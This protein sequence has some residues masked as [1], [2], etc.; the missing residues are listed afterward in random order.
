MKNFE[1]WSREKQL[2]EKRAKIPQFHERDIFWAK[3]GLNI[4]REQD[5]KGRLFTRPVIILKKFNDQSAL[6]APLS[7]SRKNNIYYFDLKAELPNDSKVVI[8]QIRFLD[9]KRLQRKI[10]RCKKNEFKELL[11]LIR[12]MLSKKNNTPQR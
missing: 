3:L 9:A 12:E 2:T 8:S 6:I 7:T 1:S 4:G 5:G 10:T 11:S